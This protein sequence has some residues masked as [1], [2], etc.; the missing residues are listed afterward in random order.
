MSAK[1]ASKNK[2]LIRNPSFK[3]IEFPN[4]KSSH[5]ILSDTEIELDHQLGTGRFATVY[6]GIFREQTVAVKVLTEVTDENVVKKEF[7]IMS[8]MRSP[9]IVYFYGIVLRPKV[10]MVMQYCARGSLAH[11]LRTKAEIEWPTVLKWC[12]QITA[13][14]RD[15]HFWEPPIIH[16]D[17][18]TLNILV[19]ESGNC[20][21]AD[22][23]ISR[24]CVEENS[25][26]L[27]K[28]RGTY[29]YCAPEI[30][31]GGS[32][33]VY[34]DVY[35]LAIIFWELTMRCLKGEYIRPY[36]EFSHIVVDFQ[37]LVQSSKG[38]RPTIDP[39]TPPLFQEMIQKTWN[40]TPD[41]RPTAKEVIVMLDECEKVCLNSNSWRKE[42][43]KKEKKDKKVVTKT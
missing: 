42:T 26:S 30:Y 9:N 1:N 16:R 25:S 31:F 4:H 35:S 20:K 7:E 6:K 22:F 38:T 2:Q 23:G 21:V 8:N 29:A 28:V 5:W 40:P 32:A 11:V 43:P 27:Y 37:V 3:S 10:C 17:L 39:E 19:D 12:Q 41:K 33:T 14:V 34:S 15:L 36:S 13:G 18:K 24:F